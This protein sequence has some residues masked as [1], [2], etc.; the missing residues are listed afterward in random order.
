MASF[1]NKE[2]KFTKAG[3]KSHHVICKNCKNLTDGYFVNKTDRKV[4]ENCS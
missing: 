3:M 4:L 2:V 1:E